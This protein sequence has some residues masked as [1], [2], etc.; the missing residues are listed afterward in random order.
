MAAVLVISFPPH[1]LGINPVP[2]VWIY[3]VINNHKWCKL[4][5]D[6]CVIKN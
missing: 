5:N 6:I 1:Y 4:Q 3:T 2:V